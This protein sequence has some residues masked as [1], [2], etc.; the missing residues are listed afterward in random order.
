[1]AMEMQALT[2][3]EPLYN[4]IKWQDRHTVFVSG[5]ALKTILMQLFPAMGAKYQPIF[6][7]RF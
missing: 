6:E 2:S 4:K 3:L 7:S 1:M 5:T